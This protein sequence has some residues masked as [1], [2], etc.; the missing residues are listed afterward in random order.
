MYIIEAI[1]QQPYIKSHHK[2]TVG[3]T[4]GHGRDLLIASCQDFAAGS[5]LLC[6]ERPADLTFPKQTG[7]MAS[8]R[9]FPGGTHRHC[10]VFFQDGIQQNSPEPSHN[11]QHPG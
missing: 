7:P 11:Q 9:L 2:V 6:N 10:D 8:S 1:A 3:G 4:A 5:S